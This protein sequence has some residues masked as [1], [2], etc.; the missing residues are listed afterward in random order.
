MKQNNN[1]E[2]KNERMSEKQITKTKRMGFRLDKSDNTWG[3]YEKDKIMRKKIFDW[4]LH[5]KRTCW[6][7]ISSH[8]DIMETKTI[9]KKKKKKK[10]NWKPIIYKHACFR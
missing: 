1:V 2:F 6:I 4:C 3:K 9:K 8:K 5:G 7:C 10:K